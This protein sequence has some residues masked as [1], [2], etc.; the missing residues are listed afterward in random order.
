MITVAFKF[1]KVPEDAVSIDTTS[2]SKEW[3]ALSPFKLGPVIVTPGNEFSQAEIS[4]N[5]ENAW[6]YSK[7]YKEH[8]HPCMSPLKTQWIEWARRG[9]RDWRANR[10]P[11]GKGAIPEYSL[12]KDQKLNYIEARKAI[13]GPLYTQTVVTTP[14]FLKLLNMHREGKHLFLLDYDGYQTEDDFNTIINNPDKK[15]GHAFFLKRALELYS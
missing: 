9:W 13:Y 14:E 15:M 1:D 12:W 8:I 10:Y 3:S 2:K 6:Q 7:V 5:V 4:R 11:M